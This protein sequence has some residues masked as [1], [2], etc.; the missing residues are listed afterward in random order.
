MESNEGKRGP[1]DRRGPISSAWRQGGLLKA[2]SV[3]G[4]AN[5]QCLVLSQSTRQSE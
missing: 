5:I 2:I 3:N 1:Q 4:L